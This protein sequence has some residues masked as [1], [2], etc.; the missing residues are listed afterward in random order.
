MKTA[1]EEVIE[2]FT[3]CVNDSEID[4]CVTSCLIITKFTTGF[5]RGADAKTED[6]FMVGFDARTNNLQEQFQL[7]LGDL[8]RYGE[9][10]GYIAKIEPERFSLN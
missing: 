1:K 5:P 4:G 9:D 10:K 6:R 7:I 8:L 3:E 2:K